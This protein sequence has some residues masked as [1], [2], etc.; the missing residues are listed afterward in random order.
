MRLLRKGFA[1]MKHVFIALI[2]LTLT[3]SPM[4]T[5]AQEPETVPQQ[6]AYAAVGYG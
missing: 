4:F 6:A 5:F 2:A 1:T 3:I